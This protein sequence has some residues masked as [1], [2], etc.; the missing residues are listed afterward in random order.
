[1]SIPDS[2]KKSNKD[3]LKSETSLSVMSLANGSVKLLAYLQTG[4]PN[5]T[6]LGKW[7]STFLEF[8]SN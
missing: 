1:M 8:I 6:H 4:H 5:L 3:E 7:S 2:S